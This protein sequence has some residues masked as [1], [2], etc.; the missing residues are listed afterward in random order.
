M[1]GSQDLSLKVLLQAQ[2][3]AGGAFSSLGSMLSNISGVAGIAASALAGIGAVVVGTAASATKMAAA[4]QAAMNLVQALTG[5]SQQQMAY[6]DVGLKQLAIDAGVAPTA[7]AQGL[8]QIISSG[9]SGT[10]AMQELTLATEDSK[11]G[12][13]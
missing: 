3:L 4:Y 11:I 10:R 13:T 1:G 9:A 6:Y 12:M 8:Y 5:S 2:N 7:L